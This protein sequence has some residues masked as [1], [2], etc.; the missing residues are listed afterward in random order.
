VIRALSHQRTRR[1]RLTW[2][3]LSAVLLRFVIPA[4]FM[5]LAGPAGMYLGFCPGAGTLPHSTAALA[6]HAAHPG[7]SHHG[8]GGAP[9]SP[10][11]SHNPG[12]IFSAGAASVFTAVP[13]AVLLA[14][15]ATATVESVA[16][17]VYLPA[18]LRAQSARGPPIPA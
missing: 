3:L 4:G 13:S 8:G 2:L 1:Q 7:H 15:Q 12:C 5:P 6:K 17:P 10:G 18:I 9:V 14:S 11:A 16:A